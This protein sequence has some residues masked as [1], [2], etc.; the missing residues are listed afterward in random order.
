MLERAKKTLSF[1]VS[2]RLIQATNTKN[3][4]FRSAGH[5]N[6]PHLAQSACIAVLTHSSMWHTYVYSLECLQS[7]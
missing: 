4:I 1:I 5:N 2:A 3:H 6:Q 7:S